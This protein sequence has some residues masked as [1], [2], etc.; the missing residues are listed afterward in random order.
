MTRFRNSVS[1][2]SATILL[3]T[4]CISET[5]AYI[6]LCMTIIV[7]GIWIISPDM[8][9]VS[10]S[11]GCSV[12]GPILVGL[13]YNYFLVEVYVFV[14]LLRFVLHITVLESNDTGSILS[15]QSKLNTTNCLCLQATIMPI[16][17]KL[18][19]ITVWMLCVSVHRQ[20]PQ[21]HVNCFAAARFKLYWIICTS[22]VLSHFYCP[23]YV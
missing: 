5:I 14:L 18:I 15:E 22:T 23:A 12:A 17:H 21:R 3:F 4:V 8:V 11:S 1:Y 16:V 7:L 9:E 13:H 2:Y 20:F 10:G 19:I 6:L